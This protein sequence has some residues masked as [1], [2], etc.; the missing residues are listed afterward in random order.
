MAITTAQIQQLYVAYLGRA[1]DK[2][3]LDYWSQQL[4]AAKPVLTLESLRANFVNEQPEYVNAYAGLS[5]SDTVIK[6]YN[7]LF[8]RAP[9][10]EGLTYWTTGGGATV[11]ADQLLT[12]FVAGAGADDAKIIANKVLVSDVYTS[13]AGDKYLAAD[14]K[15]IISG[16]GSDGTS[17]GAALNKLTDG[18]LSGIAIPAALASLKAS[19]AA[20]ATFTAFETNKAADLLAIEKQLVALSNADANIKDQTATSTAASDYGTVDTELKADLID[21]RSTLGGSTKTLTTAAAT[22]AD[23]LITA[24]GALTA[25]DKLSVDHVTAYTKAAAAVKAAPAIGGGDE[26]QAVAT[27][28]AYAN[29]SAN[30]TA[31]NKALS[32]AGITP[33]ADVA[34]TAQKVY[35][36]LT[37]ETVSASTISAIKAAFAPVTNFASVTAISDKDLAY[38]TAQAG[39]LKAAG[40]LNTVDGNAWISAYNSDVSAQS[41]L[42]SSKALDALDA[43]YKSV[44]DAHTASSAA[45][46]AAAAKLDVTDKLTDD[47]TTVSVVADPNKA[48]IFYFANNKVTTSDGALTLAAGADSLYLGEGYTLNKTAT[49]GASGITGGDNNTKE[50][51]FFKAA[52]DQYVKAV[53]ETSV[54]GSTTADAALGA[55]TT[56]QVSVITLTGVTDVSQVS[57]ANGVISHVA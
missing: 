36:A 12:A 7:N 27:L 41:K 28:A 29:N 19:A 42:A 5:R 15:S 43:A 38:N 13:T 51:F 56:D 55:H 49:L 20:D 44:D 23:N 17:V 34:A 24:R 52:G 2:A 32:D 54:L 1:A 40:D 26:A 6:I 39:L 22:T 53:I 4:N 10:A 46:I 18:S 9:D 57:F 50:V 37:D 25:S 30:T 21:A 11:N 48:E 8:G 35:N 16:V 14:A 47:G 33:G 3:G 31:W 45:K